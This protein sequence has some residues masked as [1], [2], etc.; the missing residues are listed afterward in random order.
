MFSILLSSSSTLKNMKLNLQRRW[1]GQRKNSR[2]HACLLGRRVEFHDE[3]YEAGVV[4]GEALEVVELLLLL[5]DRVLNVLRCFLCVFYG[6]QGG[7]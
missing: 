5:G 2:S 1:F 4:G 6:E 3:I 7:E